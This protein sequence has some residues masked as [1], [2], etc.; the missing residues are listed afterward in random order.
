MYAIKSKIERSH[1]PSTTLCH[2]WYLDYRLFIWGPMLD[3]CCS[4][5]NSTSFIVDSPADVGSIVGEHHSLMNKAREH[6]RKN[7]FY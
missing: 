4:K 6:I 7:M 2:S 5:I 1:T 3:Q